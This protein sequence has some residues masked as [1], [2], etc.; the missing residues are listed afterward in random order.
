MANGNEQQ[1]ELTD[2]DN[3]GQFSEAGHLHLKLTD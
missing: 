2:R 1:E 3:Q